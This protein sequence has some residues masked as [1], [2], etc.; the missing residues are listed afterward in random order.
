[1]TEKN[2]LAIRITLLPIPRISARLCKDTQL[3]IFVV[4]RVPFSKA[5]Q[6][7]QRSLKSRQTHVESD[8]FFAVS[9]GPS[10]ETAGHA[11]AGENGLP[12]GA[13]GIVWV[14][15]LFVGRGKPLDEPSRPLPDAGGAWTD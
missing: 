1:M 14:V 11:P 6:V 7:L 10:P 12:L 5:N 9:L 8:I 15:V 2:L 13:N 3:D 4:T